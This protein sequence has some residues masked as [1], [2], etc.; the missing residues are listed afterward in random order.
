MSGMQFSWRVPC[1]RCG[2]PYG[3]SPSCEALLVARAAIEDAAIVQSPREIE[4]MGFRVVVD[5]ALKDTVEFRNA[6]GSI[7]GIMKVG[8]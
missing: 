2:A 3:H 5:L 8:G 1:F 6:D 7:A 4:F